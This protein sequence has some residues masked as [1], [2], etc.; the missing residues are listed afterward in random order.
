MKQQF[1]G[2]PDYGNPANCEE[3]LL[4]VVEEPSVSTAQPG[5]IQS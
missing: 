3:E 5:V 4:N 1:A 2:L